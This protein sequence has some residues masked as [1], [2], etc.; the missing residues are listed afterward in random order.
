MKEKQYRASRLGGEYAVAIHYLACF[1]IAW[2]MRPLKIVSPDWVQHEITLYEDTQI[3]C[4]YFLPGRIEIAK[5]S[6]K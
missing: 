6:E 3:K 4:E 5:L 2:M 1:A